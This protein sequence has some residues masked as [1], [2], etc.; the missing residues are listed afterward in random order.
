M[1][2][3][4]RVERWLSDEYRKLSGLSWRQRTEYVWD[5]YK[6]WLT[7]I[8]AVIVIL[9]WWIPQLVSA[10][11]GNWFC[12]CFA[13]TYAEIGTNSDFW[14][15]YARYAGYDLREKNL[16]FNARIYCDPTR[17]NYGNEYYRL[18]IAMMDSGTA[19]VIVM[20]RERLQALGSAGRLMDLEDERTADLF[21]RYENRLVWCEPLNPDYGK[22][23]VAIG[24]DLTDSL[25]VG[26]NCAY[27]EEAV[28]GLNALSPHPDQAAVFLRYI[29][30]EDNA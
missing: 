3:L 17:E 18:L 9:C 20:E 12:A 28:L 23:S 13:N 24:I 27:P 15:E 25:L 7:G 4:E 1:I 2:T 6:L 26:E 14:R 5:Y 16:M 8:F 29:F 22:T 11:R 10:N 21:D 30:E 19:D